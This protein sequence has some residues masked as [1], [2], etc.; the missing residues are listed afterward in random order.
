MYGE[1]IFFNIGYST[2][3]CFISRVT[4]LYNTFEVKVFVL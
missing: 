3:L 2:F 1:H 4:Y